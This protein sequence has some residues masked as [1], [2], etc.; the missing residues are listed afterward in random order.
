MEW[1]CKRVDFKNFLFQK[2][3]VRCLFNKELFWNS[4][5]SL[6]FG[7]QTSTHRQQ[8]PHKKVHNWSTSCMASNQ[9]YKIFSLSQWLMTDRSR[10][11]FFCP[12][13][14]LQNFTQVAT[15]AGKCYIFSPK[16]LC[17][18]SFT[19]LRPGSKRPGAEGWG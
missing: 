17:P 13:V 7:W 10:F 16:K 19:G 2:R 9:Q 1:W 12:A 8:S 3:N 11:I 18:M 4:G 14:H 6:D 5:G 15:Q